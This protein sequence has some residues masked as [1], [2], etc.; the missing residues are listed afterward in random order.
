MASSPEQETFLN[1][2]ETKPKRSLLNRIFKTTNNQENS[3][4]LNQIELVDK[5]EAQ[6]E[7]TSQ[8][9]R[10]KWDSFTEYFLSIVG[11]V[12]D[13]GNVWRS[14]KEFLIF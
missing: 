11:F 9:E 12:I 14:N 5:N 8:P 7:D 4:N 13:L 3:A 2:K 10:L 1:N 6:I